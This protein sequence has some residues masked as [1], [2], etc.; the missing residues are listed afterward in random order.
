MLTKRVFE[1]RVEP[2]DQNEFSL[3]KISIKKILVEM[4]SI[5][6]D[7]AKLH[8]WIVQVATDVDKLAG[9]QTA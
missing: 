9:N 5:N 6:E 3:V 2:L 8:A 7:I 1:D 4:A